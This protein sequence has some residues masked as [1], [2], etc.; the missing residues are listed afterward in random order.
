M[1]PRREDYPGYIGRLIPNGDIRSITFQITDDCCCK[2]SYCYEIN[3]GHKMMSPETGKKLVDL[4]FDMYEKDDNNIINKKT[5][6]LVFDFIGG[7]PLMNIDTMDEIC[8]YFLNK[9]V[10]LHHPW[11]DFWRISMISNGKYYFTDKFQHFLKKWENYLS[12]DITIDGPK[13]LHDSCRVYHDGTGNFDDAW[14]ALTDFRKKY[15]QNFSTK[16]TISKDNLLNMNKIVEFFVQNGITYLQGNVVFEEPWTIE[17]GRIFYQELKKM[18]NYILSC[19]QDIFC[20]FFEDE[21]VFYPL[22]LEDNDNWC[23][24]TGKMLAFDPDGII[25]P[26]LR[27]MPSSLGG[28]REPIIIGN[29]EDGIFPTPKEKHIKEYLDLITRRSQST[30]EC[31]YCPIASGCAWCSGWNY[32]ENGTVN[33]RSTRICNMHKARS[34][35]NVYFWNMYY[36]LN[37]IDKVFYMN[38]SKEEALKFISEDE[39]N[40]LNNLILQRLSWLYFNGQIKSKNQLT[41]S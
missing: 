5:T 39:Y 38:L 25:Y 32:Q 4:L 17:Q 14:A 41:L 1:L 6:G 10:E 3:K 12:F 15:G 20:S 7:E 24:G 19:D 33:K 22:N 27:Y 13:E 40:M 35:A 28:E 8:S 36:Y 37:R 31:F 34:L 23:G 9:C 30:D 11:L 16:I 26:C 29:V 18:A 2:C 21:H